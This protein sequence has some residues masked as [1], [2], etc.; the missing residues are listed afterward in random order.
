M[1]NL[2][3]VI[4]AKNEKESLPQVLKE[5]EEFHIKKIVVLEKSDAETIA[6]IQNFKCEIHYQTSKGYGNALIEGINQVKT[7]YFSIF[8]ADGSFN[9]L[10]LEK[11][12]KKLENEN[13][14]IVFASRYE[15]D[16]KS[17]DDTLVTLV[18]NFIFSKLGNIFFNLKITDILYTFV[19]GNTD[20]VK[21]LKLES[22]N[23]V[24]CVELPIKAMRNKLS[25]TTSKSVERARIGGKKKV[26][27]IRDG[28]LILLGMIRLFFKR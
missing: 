23:F 1:E 2:T 21:E 24:F 16:C 25:L 3:L 22:K 10:E 12:L 17:D 13:F 18:G 7:K 28:F 20:A 9:P 8:N 14:D 5:L 19:V 6:A 11:M 15:K 27:A 4:P 26:N